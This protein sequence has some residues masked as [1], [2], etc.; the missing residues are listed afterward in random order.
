MII[1]GVRW[2]VGD[3]KNILAFKD[4]WLPRASTFKLVLVA[5]PQDFTISS[6]LHS[7]GSA[8]NL[9][10]LNQFFTPEDHDTILSIPIELIIESPENLNIVVAIVFPGFG[11]FFGGGGGGDG[12]GWW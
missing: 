8:W 12:A 2:Q 6:L 5:P 7:D 10:K 1:K 11:G 3:G 9:E 4:P